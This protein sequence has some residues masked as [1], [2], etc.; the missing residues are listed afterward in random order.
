M[1]VNLNLDAT[2]TVKAEKCLSRVSNWITS[3]GK[4]AR[5][6]KI[7][8]LEKMADQGLALMGGIDEFCTSAVMMSMLDR[9]VKQSK[10]EEKIPSTQVRKLTIWLAGC[11][12]EAIAAI[13]Q[14]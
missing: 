14:E 7:V 9:A 4:E 11:C 12:S 13:I 1:Y 3:I 2:E 5:R 10:A 8:G 6:T